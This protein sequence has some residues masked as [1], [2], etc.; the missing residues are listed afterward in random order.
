MDV[1][2]ASWLIGKDVGVNEG[3]ND[4][5]MKANIVFGDAVWELVPCYCPQAGRLV[6]ER[7]F[8]N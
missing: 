4:T 3:V 1:T 5:V 2:V 6:N 7:S 8:M